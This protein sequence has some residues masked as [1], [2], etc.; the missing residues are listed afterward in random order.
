M[1]ASTSRWALALLMLLGSRGSR[2]QTIGWDGPTGE[3][4][5]ASVFEAIGDMEA[6]SLPEGSE[7]DAA[8][9]PACPNQWKQPQDQGPQAALRMERSK[10]GP[11]DRNTR[12]PD[13]VYPHATGIP[14]QG[15][16]HIIPMKRGL[17]APNQLARDFLSHKEEGQ[18]GILVV[19]K[20]EFCRKNPW[21][22]CSAT[23]AALECASTPL[24]RRFRIYGAWV[25]EDN[26]HPQ[27]SRAWESRVM[28]A[29]GFEQGPGARI[30][31]IIPGHGIVAATN[32]E[33][34][35]LFATNLEEKGGETPKLEEFLGQVLAAAS[36]RGGGGS[37]GRP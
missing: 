34:L 35:E 3:R 22:P 20:T 28:R 15:L 7:I 8:E 19:V 12:N 37:N 16:K 6:P 27:G 32:A 18:V 9:S 4:P 36:R 29:Y 30:A 10:R 33:E 13:R 17:W 24:L 5:A 25:Q 11:V 1:R 21:R 31:A 14:F 26:P 2:A 23:T